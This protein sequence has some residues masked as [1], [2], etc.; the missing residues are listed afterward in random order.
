MGSKEKE[1]RS[2][3]LCAGC[4]VL[5]STKYYC[6]PCTNR[7]KL[8]KD[9]SKDITLKRIRDVYA[10]RKA[11]GLCVRCGSQKD[12]NDA[13]CNNCLSKKRIEQK[14]KKI[15]CISHY[16]DSTCGCCGE[17]EFIFLTIDHIDGGGNTHRRE[18]GG[19]SGK[20]PYANSKLYAWLIRNEFPEGFQVLCFSCNRGKWMNDGVCPHK[21]LETL[22]LSSFN[23][24][25]PLKTQIPN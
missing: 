5:P 8:K 10:S 24:L 20:K 6:N 18:I 17:S 13:S 14:N 2:Q 21:D 11:E 1:Y 9:A 23:L 16:S 22:R 12:N 15:K 3:G 7:R 4:G 19:N 25:S